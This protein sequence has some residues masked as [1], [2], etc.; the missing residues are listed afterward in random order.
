MSKF[1]KRLKIKSMDREQYIK[2]LLA[3]LKKLNDSEEIQK[4]QLELMCIIN[5]SKN[6]KEWLVIAYVFYKQDNM[7]RYVCNCH[8]DKKSDFYTVM[9]LLVDSGFE[10][11]ISTNNTKCYS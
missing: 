3:E 9:S 1:T 4:A 2:I 10:I 7:Q 6:T 5:E 11:S 8:I